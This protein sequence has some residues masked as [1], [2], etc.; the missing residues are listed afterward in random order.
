MPIATLIDKRDHGEVLRDV[1][2]SIVLS[3]SASQQAL[4]SAAGRDPSAWDLRVFVERDH[5]WAEWMEAGLRPVNT[6]PIVSIVRDHDA[7]STRGSHVGQQRVTT[8]F[9]LD[10]FGYGVSTESAGGHIAG[11]KA[12]AFEAQRAARLVRTIVMAAEYL[13]LANPAI[14][15]RRFI[16]SVTHY[17]PQA[18]AGAAAFNVAAARLELSVTYTEHSPQHAG[19]PLEL[20]STIVH[21]AAGE[22]VLADFAL[23]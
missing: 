22:V 19:E 4:A 9:H 12:A 21:G 2:A 11:D 8:T 10:C 14:V 23:A 15:S 7:F 5:P 18:S 13:Y 16:D 6:A 3:E 1:L 17:K 20:L